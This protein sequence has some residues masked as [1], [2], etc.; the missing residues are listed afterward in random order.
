MT[1]YIVRITDQAGEGIRR[2]AGP[3]TD[4]AT[5]DA[6]AATIEAHHGNR[7][8]AY[9]E[10]LHPSVLAAIASFDAEYVAGA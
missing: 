8:D 10:E 5:A 2:Y 1:K 7:I 3:Y 4:Q 9:V 6:L